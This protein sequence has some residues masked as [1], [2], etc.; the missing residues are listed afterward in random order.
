MT[1]SDVVLNVNPLPL[2]LHC[3]TPLNSPKVVTSF[4]KLTRTR[5]RAHMCLQNAGQSSARQCR[6]FSRCALVSLKQVQ[7]A[8]ACSKSAVNHGGC[9]PRGTNA[10][11]LEH[12]MAGTRQRPATFPPARCCVFFSQ[13]E[14]AAPCWECAM[15]A[16][17]LRCMP[18]TPR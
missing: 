15:R 16:H 2:T 13:A 7:R 1:M 11:S 9:G 5:T 17:L 10:P 6:A 12:C 4:H 8:R 3:M 14:S 18:D